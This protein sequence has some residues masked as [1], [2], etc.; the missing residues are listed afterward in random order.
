[1][2]P[3]LLAKATGRFTRASEARSR[4]G[5]GLGLA[6]VDGLVARAGGELRLC[7]AGH[8]QIAGSVQ[9]TVCCDHGPEMTVTVL[10]RAAGHG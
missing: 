10:L 1:M 3:A 9:S 2:E 6:L 7:H 8:H 5:A 4:P